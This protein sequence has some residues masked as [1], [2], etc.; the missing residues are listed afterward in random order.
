MTLL[1]PDQ[2]VAVVVHHS[3]SARDTT[4]AD[5]EQWHRERGFRWEYRGR[6]GSTGYHYMVDARGIVH[7]GRPVEV[8]GAHAPGYNWRSI[9]VCVLGR[10][11][12][13]G[14]DGIPTAQ[15]DGLLGHLAWLLDA[16]RLEPHQVLGH[17]ETGSATACPGFDPEALRDRL[18]AHLGYARAALP[19]EADT[20]TDADGRP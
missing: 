7:A 13:T 18:L 2:V 14:I 15:L 1:D 11:D 5:V 4:P 9:G 17:H 19:P 8:Q 12:R 20:D 3:A 6:S 16:Y 10:F